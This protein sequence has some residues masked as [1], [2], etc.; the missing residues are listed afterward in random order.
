LLALVACGES[1][2]PI[3]EQCLRDEDCLSN[4]CAARSCVSAPTLVTGA[5]PAPAEEEPRIPD[6]SP[7]D[8]EDS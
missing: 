8:A 7:G 3:G 4:V 6:A 1:R 2:R 5:Q